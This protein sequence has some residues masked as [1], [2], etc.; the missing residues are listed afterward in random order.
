M[1]ALALGAM[2][3]INGFHWLYARERRAECAKAFVDLK[4]HMS[5][6]H[7][8]FDPTKGADAIAAKGAKT[9]PTEN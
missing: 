4:S 8:K 6:R 2:L 5:K 1:A 3:W 7:P 9:S